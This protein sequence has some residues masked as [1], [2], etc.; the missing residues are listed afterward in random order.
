MGRIRLS[1]GATVAIVGGGP[2]GAFTAIHL[3][4]WAQRHDCPL[5]V[6]I[7]ERRLRHLRTEKAGGAAAYR[8]CPK[9][10]G[11]I[12]PRLHDELTGLGVEVTGDLV[13]SSIHSITVQ[14]KWKHIHL[15]VPENRSM[16]AVF[17]GI[18]PR[19]KQFRHPSFDQCML[20]HAASMGAV[21]VAGDFIDCCYDDI[22]KPLL[23]V[24][25]DGQLSQISADFLVFALG[26]KEG[27]NAGGEAKPV[28][29]FRRLQ[30]FYRPPGLR[31]SLVFEL[32]ADGFLGDELRGELH[33]VESSMAGLNLE[34]CSIIPKRGFV[35]LSLIGKSVDA[36]QSHRDNNKL[37][38][39]FLALPSIRRTLPNLPALRVR[40]ICN[41]NIVVGTARVPYGHRVAAVGDMV[42]SRKYKDGILSAAI[43]AR[44]LVDVIT[45]RG[46]DSQSLA[47]GYQ[48]VVDRFRR[49]NR[50][51]SV[52]FF[53]YRWFFSSSVMSRVLYQTYATELKNEPQ[54]RRVFQRIFWQISSGDSSYRQIARDMLSPL[55]IWRIFYGG[56]YI[57]ARNLFYELLFGLRWGTLGRY[58]TAVQ[59]EE[60]DDKCVQ[61]CGA[62]R[63][64]FQCLYTIHLRASPQSAFELLKTFG[65]PGRRFLTPRWV[66]IRRV[67]GEPL[68]V[69]SVIEYRILG[70]LIRFNIEQVEAR[71][72]NQV[73]YRVHG[74]FAD[75]GYFIFD[76]RADA[77]G[78]CY[79]SVFLGFDYRRGEKWLSRV[80]W[81]VFRALFPECIHD[82]LWNQ[83]LCEFKA[84]VER[85][86]LNGE[87]HFVDGDGV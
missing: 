15:P 44:S 37:I 30:P 52:I 87:A 50:Y 85:V 61:L 40:C 72:D 29:L 21:L 27:F 10:A 22:R 11:G 12:S 82:I 5:R 77:Q 35:T 20:D 13:Q 71:V 16:V 34:M 47:L 18:L 58:P 70:G 17:R 3:L 59:V 60:F 67:K 80:Y 69:G 31:K 6:V 56:L 9:C 84:L 64:E 65:E 86:D 57:S 45:T 2:G 33:F 75:G 7:V 23:S 81:R 28:E 39:D 62:H 41:P 48:A 54:Q 68:S 25:V 66:T 1:S 8:G 24:R 78:G 55:V 32:A 51:A 63:H 49:D 42:S 26:L 36:A 14:G 4:R 73:R 79:F 53:F 83:A 19:S 46:I 74:G 76:A 38:R 43:T